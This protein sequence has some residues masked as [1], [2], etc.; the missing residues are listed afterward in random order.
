MEVCGFAHADL[1]SVTTPPEAPLEKPKVLPRTESRSTEQVQ[2]DTGEQSIII[3]SSSAATSDQNHPGPL[4]GG[5]KRKAVNT[6]AGDPDLSTAK[7]TRAT[8]SQTK[9]AAL[10]EGIS[11]APPR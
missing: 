11:S 9:S 2:S 3:P 4:R 1:P 5:R 10:T 6:V 7:K 8:R